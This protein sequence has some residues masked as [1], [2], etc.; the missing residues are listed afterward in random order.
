MIGIQTYK[1]QSNESYLA[2]YTN[3]IICISTNIGIEKLSLY[4]LIK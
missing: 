3:P 2:P 1:F 4:I